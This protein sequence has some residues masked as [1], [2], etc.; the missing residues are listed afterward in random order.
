MKPIP[1][2]CAY[3]QEFTETPLYLI[4]KQIG[5]IRGS[6]A[7]SLAF[8]FLVVLFHLVRLVTAQR[9]IMV[10]YRILGNDA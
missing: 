1:W 10:T 6:R 3:A 7:Y 4:L 8:V 9:A 2:I 5:N